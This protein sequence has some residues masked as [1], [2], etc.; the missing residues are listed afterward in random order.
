MRILLRNSCANEV[1]RKALTADCAT[2]KLDLPHWTTEFLR[3]DARSKTG[4][5]TRLSAL[6]IYG[7]MPEAQDAM[8]ITM[9]TFHLSSLKELCLIC[10]AHPVSQAGCKNL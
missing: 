10:T 5:N 2:N 1:W 6:L 9:M 7:L 3:E 4:N 8:L